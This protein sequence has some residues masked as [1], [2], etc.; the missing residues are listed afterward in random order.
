VAKGVGVGPGNRSETGGNDENDDVNNDNGK[1]KTGNNDGDGAASDGASQTDPDDPADDDVN[2]DTND[3]GMSGGALAGIVVAILVVAIVAFVAVVWYRRKQASGPTSKEEF[4][5]RNPTVDMQTNPLFNRNAARHASAVSGG[6][7][8]G[9]GSQGGSASIPSVQLVPNVIYSSADTDGNA[10][11]AAHGSSLGSNNVY[12]AG[13][14]PKRRGQAQ[15][16]SNASGATLLPRSLML[17]PGTASDG[18][19]AATAAAT[20]DVVYDTNAAN[21][22]YDKWG[23]GPAPMYAT[24]IPRSDRGG[25]SSTGGASADDAAGRMPSNIDYS[26]YDPVQQVSQ[27]EIV[28]AVPSE[29]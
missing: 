17:R 3:A 12:D 13:N 4:P 27:G 18:D 9:G 8:A 6:A 21:N 22:V 14:P 26:G 7:A 16:G 15:K 19:A 20:G 11:S 2:T 28:Y 25:K 1:V 23:V 5:E 24:P 10:S 29:V